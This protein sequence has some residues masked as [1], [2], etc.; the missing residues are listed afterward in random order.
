MSGHERDKAVAALADVS[1]RWAGLVRA[2]RGGHV[3]SSVCP[4]AVASAAA[5]KAHR[6][7]PLRRVQLYC[8]VAGCAPQARLWA[9]FGP[10]SH[11]I[12]EREKRNAMLSVHNA[13]LRVASAAGDNLRMLQVLPL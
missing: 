8:S 7:L 11:A 13:E 3:R 12:N 5:G 9:G 6:L 4:T 1:Q 10:L 2:A